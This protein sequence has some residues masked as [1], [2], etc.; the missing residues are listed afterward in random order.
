VLLAA[1]LFP[2]S[3]LWL[4]PFYYGLRVLAGAW[5]AW[6][7]EGETKHYAGW[8]GKLTMVTA[9]IQGDLEALAMMPRMWAKRKEIERF[10]KLSPAQIRQL[11]RQYR[12]P[13][14]VLSRQAN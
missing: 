11:L 5:A 12:I 14:R 6:R 8:S 9:L 3:L 1:K 4:N 10:R 13:L 2:V 7:G